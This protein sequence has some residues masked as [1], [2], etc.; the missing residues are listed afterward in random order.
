MAR[1]KSGRTNGELDV[2]TA[3][4]ILDFELGK[5]SVEFKLPNDINVLV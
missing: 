2:T 3:N 1:G 4:D 5:F